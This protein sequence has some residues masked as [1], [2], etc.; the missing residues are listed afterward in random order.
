[1]L[2]ETSRSV[3]AAHEVILENPASLS[4]EEFFRARL[5]GIFTDAGIAAQDADAALAQDFRDPTDARARATAIAKIPR[6]AREVFKRVAN[7]LDD[8][9]NKKI[10]IRDEVDPKLFVSDGNVEHRLYEAMREA[11]QR[12]AEAR[13]L[14]NYAAVFESL[15][16][17]QPTVAA[18]FDK[19]GVMVMDPDPKLRDNRLALL[20]GLLR[21]YLEIADFR[22]LGGAA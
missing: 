4:V 14:R 1:V 17:L 2:F 10:E 6:E 7:I 22:K 11:Q 19:G 9:R 18:F 21:P 5:R 16:Q 12:E 15:V 3:L 20:Q 8:A 13:S